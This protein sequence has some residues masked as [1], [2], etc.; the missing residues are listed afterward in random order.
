MKKIVILLMIIMVLASCKKEELPLSSQNSTSNN[1]PFQTMMQLGAQLENPYSVDAMQ[2]PNN[3][4]VDSLGSSF[5][6]MTIYTTH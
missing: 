3:N 2:Q 4:L 1:E 6:S 5:P